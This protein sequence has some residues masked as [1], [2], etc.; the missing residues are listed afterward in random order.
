MLRILK[1][2]FLNGGVKKILQNRHL[3]G[4]LLSTDTVQGVR[5]LRVAAMVRLEIEIRGKFAKYY[6]TPSEGKCPI[7]HP[8]AVK[9]KTLFKVLQRATMTVLFVYYGP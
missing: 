8:L 3:S 5:Y 1:R 2:R 4:V 9:L 7:L 6:C